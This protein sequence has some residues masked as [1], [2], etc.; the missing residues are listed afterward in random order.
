MEEDRV[1]TEGRTP[2]HVWVIGI[3]ALL[4][5]L[6]GAYDYLMT[7]TEN[8]AYMSR[9]TAEQLDYWYGFPTWVVAAWAIAVWGGVLGAVLLLLKK[10]LAAPVFLVSFLAMVLTSIHNFLL[11]D[12]VAI[13]GTPAVAF[14]GVIF[15]FALGLWLYA[16]AMARQGVLT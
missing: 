2:W 7:Q 14:S 6:V 3:V 12:G 13:M 8:T 10:R 9:F 4:W 16:R 11:S 1:V 5:N 15:L